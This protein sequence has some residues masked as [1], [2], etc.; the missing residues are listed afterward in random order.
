VTIARLRR[1]GPEAAWVAGG[2]LVAAGAA[3]LG[4]RYLAGELGPAAYGELA[5]ALTA[6]MLSQ[7]VLIG[8][9]HGG[10]LRLYA[11]ASEAGDTGSLWQ[12]GRRLLGQGALALFALTLALSAVL[13]LTGHA[14]WIPVLTATGGYAVLSGYSYAIG[15]LQVASRDRPSVAWLQGGGEV[16]RVVT[17]VTMVVVV[18]RSATGAVL[19]YV[20][21]TA[22]LLG[23]Q[24]VWLTRHRPHQPTH[25]SP[26]GIQPGAAEWRARLI[27]YS[28]PFATWGCFYWGQVASER[29]ALQA[30]DGTEAVGRY[31]LLYQLGYLP[32]SMI[33]NA[34]VQLITPI[35][36]QR[37]GDGT[38]PA[39]IAAARRFV[40]RVVGGGFAAAMLLAVAAFV[41]HEWVFE[42]LLAPIY[43]EN[44]HLWPWMILAGGLFAIGQVATLLPL[45]RSMSQ[46]L[47]KPKIVTSL[48]AIFLNVIGAW[49]FGVA[50]VVAA[51]VCFSAVYLI[52]SIWLASRLTAV[53]TMNPTAGLATVEVLP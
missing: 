23:L 39:R 20:I 36:F 44:S 50:G 1:I 7:Q 42:A 51:N 29:W 27:R 8:P 12:A 15:G 31:A 45:A 10:L 9:L 28:W 3:F 46:A 47:V 37:A 32:A 18:S 30:F 14:G 40:F 5:L 25:D 21:A 26:G 49:R 24:Y 6:L 43:W 53:G 34:L 17:A 16:L 4:V 11:P 33:A 19:G 52:W 2:Q 35:V 38:D 48:M 41:L 22:I 13:L